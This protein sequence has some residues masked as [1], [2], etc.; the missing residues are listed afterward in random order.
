M[1]V[2]VVV[3][4]IYDRKFGFIQ[5]EH[6]R[7]DVFFHFSKVVGANPDLWY[8]GQE[9]EFE[10][11]EVRRLE[12]KVLEADLVQ[13]A[14]RPLSHMMNEREMPGMTPSIILKLEEEN[15]PGENR[16]RRL[17]KVQAQKS[18]CTTKRALANRQARKTTTIRPRSHP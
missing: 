9:V 4:L 5:S 14:S 8:A 18:P 10:L 11:N 2:G 1:R 12:L 7:D 15:R 6:F 16:T 17:L 13:V 3:K